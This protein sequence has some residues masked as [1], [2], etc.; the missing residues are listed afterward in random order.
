MPT[1][2]RI[3][4]YLWNDRDS[5][6]ARKLTYNELEQTVNELE[7]DLLACQKDKE[8]AERALEELAHIFNAVPDY[9]VAID[10]QYKIQLVNK[11]LADKLEYPQEALTGEPCYQYICMADSPPSSCPHAQMLHDGK[12]HTAEIDNR[13][14]GM[15]LLVTSS[16]LYDDAGSLIGGVHIIRDTRYI[17]KT[18]DN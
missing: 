6:M 9:I 2:M 7:Q 18:R 15:N 17:N 13:H 5:L 16:P 3:T 4:N 12:E 10:G 8:D 14:L 1:S 11:S